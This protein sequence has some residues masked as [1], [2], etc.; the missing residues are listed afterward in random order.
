MLMDAGREF[1]P[2]DDAYIK[3]LDE[4]SLLPTGGFRVIDLSRIPERGVVK[5]T[6]IA[7]VPEITVEFV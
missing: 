3:T 4:A 5:D 7:P 6:R 2:A 1:G